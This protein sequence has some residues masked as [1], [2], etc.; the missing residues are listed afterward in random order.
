MFFLC[1]L[2]VCFELCIN[3]SKSDLHVTQHFFSGMCW[4]T[5]RMCV[6]MPSDK[7]NEIQQLAHSL[8]QTQPVTVCW[9]MSFWAKPIFMPMG[10]HKLTIS[11]VVPCYSEVHATYLSFCCSLIFS[12]H[13]SISAQCQSPV[14][15]Q[16]PLPAVVV[17]TDATPSH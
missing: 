16:F 2:L 14:P 13:F 10:N 15:L 11:A 1:Y 12:F 9:V 17:A 8:L 7:L 6:S 4:D 3:F 5:V